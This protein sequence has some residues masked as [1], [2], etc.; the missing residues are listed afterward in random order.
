MAKFNPNKL[1]LYVDETEIN[2]FN[3]FDFP[4]RIASNK[5]SSG[6]QEFIKEKKTFTLN[7]ADLGPIEQVYERDVEYY[8]RRGNK[9]FFKVG[10]QRM[11]VEVSNPEVFDKLRRGTYPAKFSLV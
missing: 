11:T 2:S 3:S 10:S 4:P 5:E 8:Y 6:W 1:R 9:A 7:V